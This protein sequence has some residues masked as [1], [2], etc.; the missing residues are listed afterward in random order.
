M[1]LTFAQLSGNLY[2]APQVGIH[3]STFTETWRAFLIPSD[4]IP[5][6]DIDL[7]LSVLVGSWYRLRLDFD[8]IA[9]QWHAQIADAAPGTSLVDATDTFIG[10]TATSGLFDGVAFIEGEGTVGTTVGNLALVDNI[11]VTAIPEPATTGLLCCAWVLL[12]VFP[13]PR[14][15]RKPRSQLSPAGPESGRFDR[16]E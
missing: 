2:L 13:A 15:I 10:W 7:G 16:L 9:G 1:Q 4:A 11:N 3:A 6:A 5:G 12:E 14:A 8:A